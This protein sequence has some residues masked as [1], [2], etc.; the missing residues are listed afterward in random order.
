VTAVSPSV[1]AAVKDRVIGVIAV[2]KFDRLIRTRREGK[3]AHQ[4]PG[5]ELAFDVNVK[6]I[7]ILLGIKNRTDPDIGND[8]LGRNADLQ[9]CLIAGV[10][11]A[12]RIL[13]VGPGQG[14]LLRA[15]F[16]SAGRHS[17]ERNTRERDAQTADFGHVIPPTIAS[18]SLTR[19][20]PQLLAPSGLV[21]WD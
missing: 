19:E 12:G 11:L 4:R 5:R 15:G 3:V 9:R 1:G 13:H 14:K 20:S 21:L 10:A 8:L 7:A 16:A 17:D 18:T 6:A 2:D